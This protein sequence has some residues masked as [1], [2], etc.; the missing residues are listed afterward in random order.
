M[1][2]QEKGHKNRWDWD[3]RFKICTTLFYG[4][5][6]DITIEHKDGTR[7]KSRLYY[8]IMDETDTIINDD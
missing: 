8:K 5:N 7:K 6:K 1:K 4:K 2:D 3:K